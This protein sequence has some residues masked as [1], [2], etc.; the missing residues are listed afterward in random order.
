MLRG[1]DLYRSHKRFR[2]KTLG[3]PGGAGIRYAVG[4]DGAELDALAKQVALMGGADADKRYYTYY[5]QY[6]RHTH[7]GGEM[8]RPIRYFYLF[9]MLHLAG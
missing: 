9:V 6:E 3:K 7:D 8:C 5:Q 2:L 1:D 4:H